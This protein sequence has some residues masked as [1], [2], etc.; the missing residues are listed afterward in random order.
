MFDNINNVGPE[1]T[2]VDKL[3][4][5]KLQNQDDKVFVHES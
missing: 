3:I 4:T 1:S 2:F 5:F